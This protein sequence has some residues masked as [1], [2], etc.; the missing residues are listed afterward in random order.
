ML[1]PIRCVDFYH[2]HFLVGA[3]LA[4]WLLGQTLCWSL[5]GWWPHHCDQ[6][7]CHM[8]L[9]MQETCN[10]SSTHFLILYSSNK[11]LVP[12]SGWGKSI[13][14][15]LWQMMIFSSGVQSTNT[16]AW[17]PTRF[18]AL[19]YPFH[20]HFLYKLFYIRCRFGT[21]TACC[22]FNCSLL[23][24]TCHLVSLFLMFPPDK[25]I[26]FFDC[27]VFCLLVSC[28]LLGNQLFMEVWEKICFSF[29]IDFIWSRVT[30]HHKTVVTDIHKVDNNGKSISST[31][32]L[33]H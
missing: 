15:Y 27:W 18:L 25:K 32:R 26:G 17:T 16:V 5:S 23:L 2:V 13:W 31:N 19:W 30:M 11:Q 10:F 20:S 6:H 29:F 12:L 1:H 4:H 9:L 22:S 21:S 14:S 33:L 24:T 8:L 28:N 7:T 3:V